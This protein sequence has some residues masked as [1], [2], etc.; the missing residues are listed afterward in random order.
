[1]ASLNTIFSA[2]SGWFGEIISLMT[3]SGN[4]ILL[5]SVGLYV[6]GAVIGLA[7][8]LIGRD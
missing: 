5:V 3:A 8:R 2:I 7:C 6:F 4:E 1:M